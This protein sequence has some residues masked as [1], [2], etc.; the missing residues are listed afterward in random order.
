MRLSSGPPATPAPKPRHQAPPAAL[1]GPCTTLASSPRSRRRHVAPGRRYAAAPAAR[2]SGPAGTAGGGARAGGMRALHPSSAALVHPAG[3]LPAAA[4]HLHGVRQGEVLIVGQ[5]QR[6]SAALT[7]HIASTLPPRP[8]PAPRRQ[9]YPPEVWQQLAS[10]TGPGASVVAVSPEVCGAPSAAAQLS[11][12]GFNVINALVLRERSPAGELHGSGRRCCLAVEG[13]CGPAAAPAREGQPSAVDA[14]VLADLLHLTDTRRALQA[15]RRCAAL[16]LPLHCDCNAAVLLC[17]TAS[18]MPR[19]RTPPLPT[20]PTVPL[21][22]IRP[23]RRH[24]G[25]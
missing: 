5:Q 18:G 4:Q 14:L 24:G 23:C 7:T 22:C 6:C 3:T 8:A 12:A 21:P 1:A 9:P 19:P 11:A 13:A 25:T 15:R 2:R 20:S 10:H 16:P 17:R